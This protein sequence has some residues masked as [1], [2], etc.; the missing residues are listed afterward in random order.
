M[1]KTINR[2]LAILVS[3]VL[4]VGLAPSVNLATTA[5][6]DASDNNISAQ[7]IPIPEGEAIIKSV[8]ASIEPIK[9]GS[10]RKSGDDGTTNW[11][12]IV[13]VVHQT[14]VPEGYVGVYT[15]E[16]LDNIRNNLFG[17]GKYIVMNDI[18]V[19]S[20]DNW[21]PIGE[22]SIFGDINPFHGT[23]DGNGY[24][25]ENL[26]I[27][28]TTNEYAS[29]GLFAAAAES[30]FQNIMILNPK[31]QVNSKIQDSRPDCNVGSLAGEMAASTVENSFVVGSIPNTLIAYSPRI[32]ESSLIVGGII[33]RAWNSSISECYSQ[34]D[35]SVRGK[36]Y[37]ES[38]RYE[39]DISGGIVGRSTDGHIKN[40]HNSGT[41]FADGNAG[42]ISG[43]V[44]GSLTV[45]N[46]YNQ[47]KISASVGIAGG[48]VGL[49]PSDASSAWPEDVLITNCY[50]SGSVSSEWAGGIL[51]ADRSFE[52]QYA[53]I[54]K[55]YNTGTISSK[56]SDAGAGAGGI[57]GSVA[58][59]VDCYN[60]G[61]ISISST[62][63]TSAWKSSD[64]G[65]GG[66]A[67]SADS[68]KNCYN[69]GIISASTA[70]ISKSSTLCIGGI[71]GSSYTGKI[72]NCSNIGK[73]S[74]SFAGQIDAGGIV[75]MASSLTK[76]SNSGDVSVK[77][78]TVKG[79]QINVGGNV[80]YSD[81]KIVDSFNIG[82]ITF[83]AS[84][85]H[86]KTAYS[87]VDVGG[88][89]GWSTDSGGTTGQIS[90]CYSTGDISTST[91]AFGV[92][93]RV[94][95]VAG[96]ANKIDNTY[97]SS[98][99]SVIQKDY[100]ASLVGGIAG[101]IVVRDGNQIKNCYYSGTIATLPST[102][103]SAIGGI[104]GYSSVPSII[105]CYYIDNTLRPV[106]INTN[107][108]R[109]RNVRQL[110]VLQGKQKS[111]Y[112]GF[113]FSTDWKMPKSGTP[114]LRSIPLTH[115]PI[116]LVAPVLGITIQQ[117]SFSIAKG[118]T[119]TIPVVVYPTNHLKT[120]LKYSSSNPKVATV[121]STGKISG[122]AIGTSTIKVSA[123]N[124]KSASFKIFVVKKNIK[125]KE[126]NV[127]KAPK[128]L[129]TKETRYLKVKI[130]PINATG[131]VVKFKSS[132]PKVISVDR[133][134]KIVALKKGISTI[135]ISVGS[136]SVKK[137]I[138]VK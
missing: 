86:S 21:E 73:V 84:G 55:C 124:G 64:S 10:S 133:V 76:C 39:S 79:S 66:I 85:S 34:I 15:V 129:K 62:S 24:K 96:D 29:Y 127:S 70:S 57:A 25:I 115:N 33:G 6:A 97:S 51:G 104:L 137:I 45:E 138:T 106:G 77:A 61:T 49:A 5:Y 72:E 48:C 132:N 75:G 135:T 28:V 134:G 90:K 22:R 107:K 38:S 110:T 56:S 8:N 108:S 83:S 18:D 58:I 63:S 44:D 7:S 118:K 93:L 101:D 111:S 17:N 20:V 27:N 102:K 69:S 16:D 103:T 120:K 59:V 40:C 98:I 122:K 71:V 123:S 2:R 121:T 1:R 112:S 4:I 19:S 89:A 43:R 36:A 30:Q 9:F 31:I 65:I 117:N 88:I 47:G 46:C 53:T 23:F 116:H 99:I 11:D 114:V 78:I 95:G 68:I 82:N 26:K 100:Y 94:G 52:D 109:I 41:V 42:G 125:V 67:A 32:S 105:N 87:Y 126:V 35:V 136:M 119:L 60:T 92:A 37:T 81:A 50:N 13:P 12:F 3:V 113:N 128:S 130:T 74:T 14:T 54:K 91:N 80:G 131:A